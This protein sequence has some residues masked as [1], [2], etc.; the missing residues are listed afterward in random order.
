MSAAS[1]YDPVIDE[2]NR[3][4]TRVRCKTGV[5][6]DGRIVFRVYSISGHRSRP[7]AYEG[8][9]DA[10][11][12]YCPQTRQAYLVP[13]AAVASRSTMAALRVSAARN[14]QVRGVRPASDFAI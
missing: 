7:N 9:I 4:F 2:G 3:V 11:G 8:Q 5:L 14:G 13:M 12:V 10:F 1:R 6:R